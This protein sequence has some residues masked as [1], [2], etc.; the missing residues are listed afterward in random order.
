MEQNN[1]T[2]EKEIK[3]LTNLGNDYDA[4]EEKDLTIDDIENAPDNPEELFSEPP[5]LD[6]DFDEE[7]TDDELKLEEMDLDLLNDDLAWKI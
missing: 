2:Q 6:I 3:K 5:T 4:E 7:P 1:K